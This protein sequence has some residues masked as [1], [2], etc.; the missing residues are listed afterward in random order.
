MPKK[1]CLI[2]L[3]GGLDSTVTSYMLKRDGYTLRSVYFDYGKPACIRERA[4]AKLIALHLGMPLEIVD[5]QGIATMELGYLPW[6]RVKSDSADGAKGTDHIATATDNAEKYLR[7]I[8]AGNS[9]WFKITGFHTL[10]S[11][12]TYLAQISGTNKIAIG[13]TKEQFKNSPNLK[14]FIRNWG[15][16]ISNLNSD[17]DEFEVM[18]PLEKLIKPQIIKIGSKL[19][20]PLDATWSCSNV[21]D[22]YHCGKCQRCIERIEG[23][24]ISR[25]KDITKYA[26]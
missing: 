12:S 20:A 15:K 1:N 9:N 24:K 22:E 26:T 4:S 18:T 6:E 10:L 21:I 5:I 7:T 25:I 14:P 13:I 11:L 19:K 16:M 17:I 23:F 3:S 8:K 2:V